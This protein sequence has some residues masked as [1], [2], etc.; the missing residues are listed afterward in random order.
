MD[1]L[2]N[3][4]MIEK[5]NTYA[6]VVWYHPT[7]EQCASI[8]SYMEAVKQVIIVDNTPADNTALVSVLPK[9][10]YVYLPLGANKGIATALN[11]GCRKAIEEG[12]EWILTMDQDSRW[13]KEQ[14]KRY[15]E[16]ANA[17]PEREQVGVFSPRQH[18]SGHMPQY[19]HEYEEQIAVMT[20]GCLISVSGFEAT[21]GFRDEFF[22]DEVDNEYCMHC[23]R[24]G[25]KVVIVNHALLEHRLG[26]LSTIRFLGIWP[27]EYIDHA[28]FRFYY[29]TRNILYLNQL[30]PEHARFNN[31][32]LKKAIK[33]IV[34]YDRRHKWSALCMCWL[35][36]QD[37]KH[38]KMNQFNH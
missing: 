8:R 3:R 2:R 14:L 28:P 20:S 10:R 22:I 34:L 6:V 32:R 23:R 27:K 37:Y 29:I 35:G 9:G 33:R 31:K 25:M 19:Q 26:E 30:Y 17:Y 38:H 15:F 13:E 11:V 16:L 4:A 36:W 18:Y 7:E 21:G 12:A 1:T 24:L 5:A